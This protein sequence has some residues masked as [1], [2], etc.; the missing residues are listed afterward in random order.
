MP[1]PGLGLPIHLAIRKFFMKHLR[2]T[3][4]LAL[5]ACAAG[6]TLAGCGGGGGDGAN[7]TAV[8]FAAEGF[9]GGPD[10]NAGW[11]GQDIPPWNGPKGHFWGSPSIRNHMG[12][13]ILSSGE[14]WGVYTANDVIVGALHG[15]AQAGG[16]GVTIGDA[17]FFNIGY[18]A[19]GG[20]SYSGAVAPMSQIDITGP[21]TTGSDITGTKQT[22]FVGT[23]STSYDRPASL[24]QLAGSYSG[25]GGTTRGNNPGTNYSITIS[26]AGVITLPPDAVGCSA[27]GT[28][29]PHTDKNVFDIRLQ[30]SGTRCA[31]GNGA[32]VR[33]IAVL[34]NDGHLLMMGAT[35]N[36]QDQFIYVGQ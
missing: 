28:A 19:Q 20:V 21:D 5:L 6:L 13:V 30:F 18:P 34:G 31:L 10:V 23:Y 26:G 14:T 16:V 33:G 17:R 2:K 22:Q 1:G 32:Q 12:L 27:S 25:T 11:V 36:I 9:W 8:R 35:P 24:T 7:P 29:T 4:G 15:S 3:A